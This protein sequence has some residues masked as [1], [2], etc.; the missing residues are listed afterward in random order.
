MTDDELEKLI[1]TWEHIVGSKDSKLS[2]NME[3]LIIKTVR[4]L[5]ILKKKQ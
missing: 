5:H 2:R 4:Q 1:R 3:E